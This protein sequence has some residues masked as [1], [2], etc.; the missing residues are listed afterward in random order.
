MAQIVEPP[1]VSV[2]RRAD[3]ATA[4]GTGRGGFPEPGGVA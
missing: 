3:A 2:P 4:F 1:V